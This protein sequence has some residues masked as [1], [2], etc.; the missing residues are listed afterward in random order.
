MA[1]HLIV[2][3]TLLTLLIVTVGCHPAE[4]G[5]VEP[6]KKPQLPKF[7][8]PTPEPEEIEPNITEPSKTE[9]PADKPTATEPEQTELKEAEP[10]EIEPDTTEPNKT[11]MP[12]DKPA[13][14]ESK[15]IESNETGPNEVALTP[16]P[17][18]YEKYADILNTFVDRDGM[19]DYDTLR[20]RRLDL[21]KLLNEFDEFDPNKYKAWPREDKIAFWINAY[22]LQMLNIIVDNYPIEASRILSIFWGPYSIRHIKGIWT[23]YKFLV[24]DEEFTLTEVRQRF[25]SKEFDEP[26]IFLAISYACLSSPFL[27]NE[28]YY[29]YKLSEQLEEQTKRFLS[30]PLAF[31]IDRDKKIVYLSAIFQPNWHGNEFTAKFGTDKKFKD[32]QPATRAVLNF[33][34]NYISGRDVSFLEVDNYSVKYMKYDWIL[35]DTSKKR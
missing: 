30:S 11:E 33:I 9:M 2:F 31:R 29:G 19:V 7:E 26:R 13:V 12:E 4:T 14:V 16:G 6:E 24:M 3:I 18:F 5:P 28:P 15:Q 10:N 17:S 25:F 20:R 21:K 35:N 32:Q 22:N 27:R 1:R 34:T 23:D 8:P